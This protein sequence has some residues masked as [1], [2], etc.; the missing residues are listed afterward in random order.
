M[1]EIY[2]TGIKHESGT[3]FIMG[4]IAAAMQGLGYS[5]AVYIPAQ[6]GAKYKDGFI[7]APDVL[8]T[9]F[10]DKNVTTYCS[11]LYKSKKL[12][13]SVFAAERLYMDKNVIFQDYMNVVNSHE[14]V[15]VAGQSD[16]TTLFETNFNEEE[17]LRTVASPIVLVASMRNATPDEML[18][19]LQLMKRKQMNIRGIIIN[20]CPMDELKTTGRDLQKMLENNTQIPVLGLIPHIESLKGL[21]PEDWIEYIICRTDLEAIFDV[22]ISK[23]SAE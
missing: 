1:L 18:D 2:L 9:K 20:G 14:C 19:Y 10:L 11:Y 7:Q 6:T 5:T 8:F 22:K 16:M 15:I 23:L 21:R 13:P 4:G 17:L 3:T 12:S